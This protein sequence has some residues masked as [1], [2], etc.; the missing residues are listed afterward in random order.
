MKIYSKS[1]AKRS[2]NFNKNIKDIKYLLFLLLIIVSSSTR[3]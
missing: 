1:I 3:Y 2:L